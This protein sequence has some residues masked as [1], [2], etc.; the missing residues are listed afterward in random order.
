MKKKLKEF[1]YAEGETE[2]LFDVPLE[3]NIGLS[4]YYET[5]FYILFSHYKEPLLL[6]DHHDINQN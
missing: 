1:A 2:I 4:S 3:D 5:L 6:W